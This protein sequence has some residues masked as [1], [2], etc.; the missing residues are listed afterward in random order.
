MLL[1]GCGARTA[2]HDSPR[3]APPFGHASPPERW[4]PDEKA[5]PAIYPDAQVTLWAPCSREEIEQL[6]AD[7]DQDGLKALQAA[8]CH[9]ALVVRASATSRSGSLD[10]ARDGRRYAEMACREFPESGL[11]HYLVALLTGLEAEHNPARGL[12]LVPVIE[13]EAIL[14]SRLNPAVDHGGPDRL[15]G[16]LYLRAPGFPM[17]LGDSTKSAAH[18]RRALTHDADHLEN[19]LGLVEA[20]MAGEENREACQELSIVIAG[21]IGQDRM[22]DSVRI[23]LSLLNKLCSRLED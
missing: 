2:R 23:A 1:Y 8:S 5:G 13:R 14:A 10:I 21:V 11:A 18:F 17:S 6:S 3:T 15:L 22:E 7:A 16:E 4:V 20:L 12:Q 9:A 19:R